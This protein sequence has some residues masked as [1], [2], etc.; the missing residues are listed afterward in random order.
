MGEIYA[1]RFDQ[2]VTQCSPHTQN[3]VAFLK[4]VAENAGAN[5][6]APMFEARGEGI[7]YWTNGR[8]FCRFDP[9][10]KADHVW[11]LIPN[12]DR[13]ALEEAG[14]VSDRE[15]GPWVTITSMPGAVRLV[16][17][18]LHAYDAAQR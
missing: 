13:R 16:R 12:A 8:R 1:G 3:L 2:R 14:I 9:K 11:A 10:H 6:T 17:H 18:I 15:D 4:T 7:T 5:V